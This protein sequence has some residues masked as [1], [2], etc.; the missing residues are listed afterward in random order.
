[1]KIRNQIIVRRSGIWWSLLY[2]IVFQL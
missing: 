1:M 2:V